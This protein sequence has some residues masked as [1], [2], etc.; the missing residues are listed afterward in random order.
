MSSVLIVDDEPNIRRMV[1]ALLAAEG[2]E[3]RDAQDGATGLAR[4]VEAEPDV[5]LLDL[6]MPGEL[7]GMAALSQLR[8]R[9]PALPVAP[10]APPSSLAEGENGSKRGG[11]ALVSRVLPVRYPSPLIFP[12]GSGPVAPRP[13]I[14]WM[15]SLPMCTCG[16]ISSH[17]ARSSAKLEPNSGGRPSRSGM[18]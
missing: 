12:S 6:M 2:Y 1:G 9:F 18:T 13:S 7:D 10:S 3:V 4:A 16:R 8:E 17:A 5:L 14:R 15:R 11:A